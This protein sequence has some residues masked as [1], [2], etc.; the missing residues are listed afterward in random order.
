MAVRA[1][2][3]LEV[4]Q[5]LL[6]ARCLRG[7]QFV[8]SHWRG[9]GGSGVPTSRS[10]G[11]H[12]H[13]LGADLHGVGPRVGRKQHADLR[14]TGISTR[15]DLAPRD[16]HGRVFGAASSLPRREPPRRERE[17]ATLSAGGTIKRGKERA[18]EWWRR[19]ARGFPRAW[20]SRRRRQQQAS[21]APLSL[22]VVNNFARPASSIPGD[23]AG[24]SL[25]HNLRAPPPAVLIS[26]RR[27]CLLALGELAISRLVV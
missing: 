16:D 20:M 18:S 19:C 27:L 15:H 6:F 14:L 5:P 3:A 21:L 1:S 23:H 22:I 26:F 24:S 13:A 11:A 8:P 10:A 9:G 7:V 17:R 2:T 25:A 4:M 12:S